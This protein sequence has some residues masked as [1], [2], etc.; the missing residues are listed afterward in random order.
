[1]QVCRVASAERGVSRFCAGQGRLVRIDGT[2]RGLDDVIC[3]AFLQGRQFGV[4]GIHRVLRLLDRLWPAALQHQVEF[5]LLRIEG[6]LRQLDV[7]EAPASLHVVELHLLLDQA[8]LGGG[9]V[10]GARATLHRRQLGLSAGKAGTR[11]ERGDLGAVL[12]E[13]CQR[14][15]SL[16]VAAHVDQDAV[17]AA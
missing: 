16:D 15:A 1:M 12:S 2:L 9:H 3:G 11:L 14:V 7:L 8:G 4:G 6:G 13:H 10:L 5:R 17:H